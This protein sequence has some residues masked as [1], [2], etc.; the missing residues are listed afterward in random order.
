MKLNKLTK[1]ELEALRKLKWTRIKQLM[2]GMYIN[3]EYMDLTQEVDDIDFELE[4]R[5]SKEEE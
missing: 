5:A 2:E 1:D 3:Q 4:D